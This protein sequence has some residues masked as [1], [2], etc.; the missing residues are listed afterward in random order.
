M[1]FA[2]NTAEWREKREAEKAANLAALALPSRALHRGS[3][4]GSTSGEVVEKDAPVR[5][6][7]YRRLVALMAC[8]KCGVTGYSQAAH[9]NFGKGMGIKTDD[10]LCF[11]L[12]GPRFSQPGCHAI[13][14][15]GGRQDKAERR[16]FEMQ[17]AAHTRYVIDV[18][19]MWPKG[20]PKL[21]VEE[22]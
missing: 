5:S 11:P 8:A 12:C 4:S 18:A 13:H 16:E 1:T 10:R 14:D 2:R 22:A 3:Y 6:E 19:G 9:P 15:Q 21:E 20:L 7:P 17:A